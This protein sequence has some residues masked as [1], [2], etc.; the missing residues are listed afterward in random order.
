MVKQRVFRVPLL[1]ERPALGSGCCAVLAEDVIRAE[2]ARLIGVVAI[3]VD[4]PAGRVK[5]SYEPERLATEHLV[6]ALSGV[7]YPAEGED[8]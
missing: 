2:L 7:G 8:V 3:A 6:Q 5:V 4:Q 1:I